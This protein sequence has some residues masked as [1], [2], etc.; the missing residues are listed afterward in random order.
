[1]WIIQERAGHFSFNFAIKDERRRDFYN[2]IKR[3]EMEKCNFM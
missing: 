2:Y 3:K 1:M